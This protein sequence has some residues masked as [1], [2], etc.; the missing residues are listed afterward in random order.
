MNRMCQKWVTRQKRVAGLK[1]VTGQRW[2]RVNYRLGSI[3]GR[4]R[5]DPCQGGSC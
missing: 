3:S 5:V 2:L 1:R 4:V